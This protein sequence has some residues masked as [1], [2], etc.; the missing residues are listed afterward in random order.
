MD[1]ILLQYRI[2]KSIKHDKLI[3]MTWLAKKA[4][5]KCPFYEF[6][7]VWSWA[8]DIKYS[9]V[10]KSSERGTVLMWI[11]WYLYYVLVTCSPAQYFK[12]WMNRTLKNDTEKGSWQDSWEVISIKWMYYKEKEEKLW[13]V[14]SSLWHCY[15]SQRNTNRFQTWVRWHVQHNGNKPLNTEKI[16]T[17]H[18]H[19][20][21]NRDDYGA[22]N[23]EAL[24]GP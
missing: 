1:M 11:L 16:G 8:I 19:D 5:K 7:K 9:C 22:D 6:L 12:N 21:L 20:K 24:C 13:I 4:I 17:V 14:F 18:K 3:K 15:V 23:R 2:L 10:L